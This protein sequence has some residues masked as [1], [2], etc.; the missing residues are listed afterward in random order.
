M[1]AKSINRSS[2]SKKNLRDSRWL[3]RMN[4]RNKGNK[5]RKRKKRLKRR[6]RKKKGEEK[7][8]KLS[9]RK[10]NKRRNNKKQKM[11][12]RW[13]KGSMTRRQRKRRSSCLKRFTSWKTNS[14]SCSCSWA[15]LLYQNKTRKSNRGGKVWRDLEV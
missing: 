3:M 10:R 15:I 9:E 8:S 5:K 11:K 13:W 7:F 14:N 4:K 1:K 6:R 2:I 12:K